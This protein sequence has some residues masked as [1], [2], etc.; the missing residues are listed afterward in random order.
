MTPSA[1]THQNGRKDPTDGRTGKPLKIRPPSNLPVIA[2]APSPSPYLLKYTNPSQSSLQSG[3]RTSWLVEDV[4]D[5]QSNLPQDQLLP[6]DMKEAQTANE[7]PINPK[8]RKI[9]FAPVMYEVE[10]DERYYSSEEELSSVE[11]D[12]VCQSEDFDDDD[13]RDEEDDD[14]DE[15]DYVHKES[16]YEDHIYVMTSASDVDEHVARIITFIAPGKPRI[17]DVNTFS[18]VQRL[19]PTRV[20]ANPI[21]NSSEPAGRRRICETRELDRV[22][23]GRTW[24]AKAF[25]LDDP[26]APRRL[27]IAPMNGLSDSEGG[28]SSSS[29]GLL[30]SSHHQISAMLPSCHPSASGTT[31]SKLRGVAHSIVSAKRK[32]LRPDALC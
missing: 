11:N 16:G 14:D 3:D 9:R 10:P 5:L 21:R 20:D 31:H 4:D 23:R 1:G 7:T 19:R 29:S 26:Y 13:A 30:D 6:V 18:P 28:S 24:M 22:T 32:V 12:S 17:I 8:T 2:G 27:T 25:D 15:E